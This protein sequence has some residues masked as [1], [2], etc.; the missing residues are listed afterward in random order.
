MFVTSTLVDATA[1]VIFFE[2][3]IYISYIIKIFYL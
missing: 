3:G 1:I 2:R